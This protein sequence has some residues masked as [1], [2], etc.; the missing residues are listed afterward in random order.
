MPDRKKQFDAAYNLKGPDD[1]K[2]FYGAWAQDYDTEM[3]GDH[4]YTGPARLAELFSQTVADRDCWVLDVG[5]GTGLVGEHLARLGFR[6]IDGLDLVP[7]MLEVASSK[8]VYTRLIQAD[9]LVGAALNPNRYDAALSAGTFTHAHVGPDGLDEVVRLV[10][11][12]GLAMIMVNAEAFVGDGYQAK[13]DA[14]EEHGRI[15]Q[16]GWSEH[17]VVETGAVK[18]RLLTLEIA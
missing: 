9:L 2:R 12:G 1:A 3:V 7:E 8:K 14:L 11:P 16:L 13:L 5:C 10:K 6:N 17:V 18:G 15:V 4:G